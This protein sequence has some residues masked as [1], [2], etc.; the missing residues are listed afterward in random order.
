ML[1][2]AGG[3]GSQEVAATDFLGSPSSLRAPRCKAVMVAGSEPA[4]PDVQPENERTALVQRLDHHRALVSNALSDVPWTQAS[5]RLLPRTDLTIAGVVRHLA[6]A[7]DR[8]FQG[9]LLGVQMPAPWDAPGADDPDH[10]MRF[11]SDDTLEGIAALYEMACMR[12]RAAIEQCESLDRVAAVPSFGRGPV[13]LRWI[14][15][16]MVDETARHLGHLDLLRDALNAQT[17]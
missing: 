10:S 3:T 14:L 12:S 8:W 9:R 6:W 15:V 2:E 16:H 5:R 1:S 7:E 13:N 4:Y 11:R 17:S